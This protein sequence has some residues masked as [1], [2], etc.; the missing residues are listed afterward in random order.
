[1]KRINIP[2]GASISTVVC[3]KNVQVFKLEETTEFHISAF[4]WDVYGEILPVDILHAASDSSEIISLLQI[5]QDGAMFL[6]TDEQFSYE[7]NHICLR[8]PNLRSWDPSLKRTKEPVRP[9]SIFSIN[10]QNQLTRGNE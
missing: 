10:H 2:E 4:T 3:I 9:E 1:M 7:N 6:I 8:F 5:L